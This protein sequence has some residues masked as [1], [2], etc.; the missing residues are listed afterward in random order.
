M[1][2]LHPLLKLNNNYNLSIDPENI[3]YTSGNSLRNCNKEVSDFAI[4]LMIE[5]LML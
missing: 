4:L 1:N 5:D 3:M 2:I